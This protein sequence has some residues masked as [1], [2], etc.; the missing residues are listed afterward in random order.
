MGINGPFFKTI[1]SMYKDVKA[2]VNCN[3]GISP[4]FNCYKG[5]RQGCNLSPI[6]FA[7]FINDVE[8]YLTNSCYT[9]ICINGKNICCL[10][11]ADDLVIFSTNVIS[12][13]GLLSTL[14]S[15]CESNDL[16]LN[17]DKTKTVVFRRGGKLANKEKWYF[18][19]NLIENVN[20]Y[21]Y[22]GMMFTTKG[23][24]TMAQEDISSAAKKSLFSLKKMFSLLY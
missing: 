6:L 16:N 7:L 9:G 20:H 15:H 3:E 1:L 21:N 10:L 19:G 11:Y 18:Q 22:L 5:V 24:W 13:Q 17:I 2:C 8:Y 14:Q 12:L 23:F 4:S